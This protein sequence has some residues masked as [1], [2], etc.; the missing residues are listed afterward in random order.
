M[1]ADKAIIFTGVTGTFG[2]AVLKRFLD[3]DLQLILKV[4]LTSLFFHDS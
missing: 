2:N 3:T 4:K 1:F